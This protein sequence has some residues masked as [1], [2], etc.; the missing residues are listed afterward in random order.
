VNSSHSRQ[1]CRH[2]KFPIVTHCTDQIKFTFRCS[3]I[4]KDIGKQ[5]GNQGASYLKHVGDP[6]SGEFMCNV[7]VS[8]ISLS[9]APAKTTRA[10]THRPHTSGNNSDSGNNN[11]AVTYT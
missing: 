9:A 7:L 6:G 8:I 3:I 11:R 10:H 2:P 5:T 1:R 4:I